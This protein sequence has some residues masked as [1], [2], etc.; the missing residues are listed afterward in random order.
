M[1][2]KKEKNPVTGEV[3]EGF[4]EE[5]S[6]GEWFEFLQAKKSQF[7]ALGVGDVHGGRERVG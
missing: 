4:M 5:V 2:R 7:W 1:L 6:F 3:T